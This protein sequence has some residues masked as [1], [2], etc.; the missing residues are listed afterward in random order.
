[1]PP[2]E[3]PIVCGVDGSMFEKWFKRQPAAP[4]PAAPPEAAQ[5]PFDSLLAAA[6]SALERRESARA[7]ELY[8]AAIAADPARPEAY[9]RRGNLLKD[10]GRL[11]QAIDSYDRAIERRPDYAYAYCNRGA[12]QHRLGLLDAALGSLDRAL[13]LTPGDVFAHYNRALVLQDAGRWEEALAAYDQAIELRPEFADAYCN[14]GLAR[15]YMGDFAGGWRDQ[16][17]RWK[18]AQRLQIGDAR[19]LP[20]PVWLGTPAIEG[21]RLLLWSEGGLGDT[22]QFC[23]YATLAAQQGATVLLEVQPALIELMGTLAG[24]SEIHPRNSPP[25]S[26]DLHCPLMSLPLAFGT[27]VETVPSTSPYLR[28]ERTKVAEWRGRLGERG[29]PRV[30]LAWSGNPKNPLDPRRSFRLADWIPHLPPEFEYFCIQTQ[31]RTED[32]G[33]L[34]STDLIYSFD[35][36]LMDFNYTAALCEC[37]DLIISVDTSLAHLG[38]ALGQ[39]TW[40][41]L[42]H[43]PDWRWLRDRE[44][45]PWYPSVRLYRQAAPGAW[46]TVFARVANDLRRELAG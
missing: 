7:L 33:L 12:V 36:A 35:D 11:L 23:R 43:T 21:K 17:W 9:Y 5:P 30:G 41:L 46:D 44:D 42:S 15:L 16:E 34:E 4:P 28:A 27:T 2:S 18:N 14:R 32:V 26:F 25:P 29:R 45:T 10:E 13:A 24:V 39:P 6:G 20:Q 37:L 22:L 38:G 19:E 3:W 40:V 1:V 31:V 8:E